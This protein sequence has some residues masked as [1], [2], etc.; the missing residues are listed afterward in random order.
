ML[1]RDLEDDAEKKKL[2]RKIIEGINSLHKI[3]S[4]VLMYT[5]N[6]EVK[7]EKVNVK[8]VV[9]DAF[10]LVS[11]EAEEAGI[12]CKIDFPKEDIE[13]QVDSELFRQMLLNLLKNAVNSMQKG[14]KLS[15]NLSWELMHNRLKL[16][17]EDSGSGI[18][19]DD[20]DKIFNPFFTTNASGSGLGLAI[21]GK[22]LDLHNGKIDVESVEG[23]G[24][25]FTLRLPIIMQD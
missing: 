21:V 18:K 20:I 9:L 1:E 14:G 7:Y 8:N 24:T 5:R 25:K 17:V 15:I 19:Q 22:I 6:M 23:K 11:L 13:A 4:D 12:E 2:V 3:T 10:S 16:I